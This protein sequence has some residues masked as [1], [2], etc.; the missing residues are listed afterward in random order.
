MAGEKS[1]T[2]AMKEFFG[3][4]PGEGLAQFQA[5]LKA[6]TPEDKTYFYEGLKKAGVDCLPPLA[7]KV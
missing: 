1:F 4:R 2:I 3:Y 6:L 7:V 5:E